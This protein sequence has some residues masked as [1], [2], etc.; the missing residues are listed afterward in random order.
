VDKR[1]QVKKAIAQIIPNYQTVVVILNGA[2]RKD[3]IQ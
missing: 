2:I 1:N 3:A